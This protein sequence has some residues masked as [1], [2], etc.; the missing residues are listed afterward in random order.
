MKRIAG[1]GLLA[2][3][4][5]LSACG[6]MGPLYFDEDPPADQ[7]PPSISRAPAAPVE[8]AADDERTQ[9][10]VPAPDSNEGATPPTVPETE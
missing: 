9:D 5:L 4:T 8:P 3:A 2:A 10:A 1:A 6:Q 7:L